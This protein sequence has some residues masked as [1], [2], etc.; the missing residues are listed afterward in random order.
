[1]SST[2]LLD[3]RAI[4]REFIEQLQTENAQLRVDVAELNQ[5]L[6]E[7]NQA[8]L[9]KLVIVETENRRLK[10]LVKE[11]IPPCVD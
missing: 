8:Y 1:M 6:I 9:E 5:R 11:L 2:D 7:A 10:K 4:A 3:A